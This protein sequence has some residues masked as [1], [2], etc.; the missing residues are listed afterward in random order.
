[1]RATLPAY[2]L[3]Y[4]PCQGY[5]TKTIVL[6]TKQ[7]LV[8]PT[9]SYYLNPDASLGFGSSLV[10][11]PAIDVAAG[12]LS[13]HHVVNETNDREA[14]MT[15]EERMDENDENET[16]EERM[17]ENDENDRE[18]SITPEQRMDERLRDLEKLTEQ[19]TVSAES[20]VDKYREDDP[21]RP[22][23]R[24]IEDIQWQAMAYT[25][26]IEQLKSAENDQ[27]S[28]EIKERFVELG[29]V[30]S[31]IPNPLGRT[32]INVARN[33]LS[34]YRK[35]L[36]DILRDFGQDLLRELHFGIEVTA[37]TQVSLGTNLS[38][39]L[40]IEYVAAGSQR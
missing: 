21:A 27:K 29:L 18:A 26:L 2:T 36:V 38:V 25:N 32:L 19:P 15:P 7:I 23:W 28:N 35:V 8:A 22:V 37:T 9:V 12:F 10:G 34:T 33:K 4:E 3:V 14:S 24:L 40:G 20:L 5:V 39:S 1:M 11:W 17:D 30:P 6:D 16:F 13:W 31:D